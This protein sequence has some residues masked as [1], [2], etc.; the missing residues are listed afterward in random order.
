MSKMS[1]SLTLGKASAA[2]GANI[3]HNNREYVASNVDVS[4]IKDNI[5]YVQQPVREAYHELFDDALTEYNARQTRNDRKIDNYFEHISEGRREEAYYEIV[6]QFG[7]S[8][9]APVGSDMGKL[10]TKM[11]DEYM[12]DFQKRNKNL[13]VFNAILH[14]DE[15]SPHLHINVIPFYSE[16]RKK[17]LSKGVSMKAALDEQGF[18]AKNYKENRLVAWEDSERKI[19]EDI[20]KKHGFYRDYKKTK[21]K[22]LSVE[23]FKEAQDSKKRFEYSDKNIQANTFTVEDYKTIKLERDLLK[24]ENEKL[25]DEKKSAWKSFY[26]SDSAKHLFVQAELAQIGI[27]FRETDSGFEAQEIYVDEIRKIEKQFKTVANPNRDKLRDDI[28]KFVMQ[29]KNFDEL[30]LRLK[31]AGYEIKTGK[32]LAFKPKFGNQFIRIKS[33]GEDYSEMALRN[34]FTHKQKFESDN[35]RALNF[36]EGQDNSSIVTM[37]YKAVRQYT[38]IFAQGYLPMRKINKRKP[39]TWTND[40]E[41]NKLSELNK[42]I[43]AGLTLDNARNEFTALESS[44]A[45][46]E[47][48]LDRLK[49]EL[50]NFYYLQGKAVLCFENSVSSPERES[51][52]EIMNRRNITADNYHKIK[53]ELIFSNEKEIAEIEQ[54]LAADRAKIKESAATLEALERIAG[55]TYVQH[56]VDEE[57]SRRQGQ[58]V[59]GIDIEPVKPMLK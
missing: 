53:D 57:R 47:A 31:N 17:G 25:T 19:M 23:Q 21:R 2:H 11:L 48:E 4:R 45:E 29:S 49:A 20:L 24:Q 27:P 14:L 40:A 55:G 42:K 43:N 33:L 51:A 6:V 10:A 44:I 41:L 50:K 38:V 1:I 37:G 5:V 36:A 58:S 12:I 30:L 3:E 34:R 39:F 59:N 9:F 54:L 28:D 46:H 56:L 7:D 32:Y 13:H 22:H 18:T 8:K 26:Y 16:G 52:M 15:T 35:N